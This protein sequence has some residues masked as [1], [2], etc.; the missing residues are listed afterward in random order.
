MLVGIP[1]IHWFNA[2]LMGFIYI[3]MDLYTGD[4]D[5]KS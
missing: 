2:D 3:Y 4:F 1:V 5:G